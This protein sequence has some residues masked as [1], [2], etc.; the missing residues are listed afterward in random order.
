MTDLEL[1]EELKK[2]GVYYYRDTGD[3]LP[4]YIW[5]M[6]RREYRYEG[7]ENLDA[8]VQRLVR[9][10]FEAGDP[11]YVTLAER[12]AIKKLTQ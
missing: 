7:P 12:I 5:W 4:F 11:L 3:F 8:R 10:R 2:Q 1:H 6:E 9:E